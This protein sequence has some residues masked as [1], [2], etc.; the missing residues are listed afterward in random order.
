M[1]FPGAD[2]YT[3]PGGFIVVRGGGGSLVS[4]C[5]VFLCY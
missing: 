1:S 3:C 2:K 5:Q 4:A